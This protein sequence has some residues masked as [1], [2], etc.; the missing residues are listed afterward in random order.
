EDAAVPSVAP[1]ATR[2]PVRRSEET[3][4]LKRKL[5]FKERNELEETEARIQAAERRA[6][7]IETELSA[8][9]SDA[10]VVHR[11][12]QER[13]ELTKQLARDLDRWAEL[14]EFA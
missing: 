7:E 14:A 3:P 13:E 9:S 10:H 11:L 8:N 12:Y 5:S 2:A 4:P 6:S 1:A